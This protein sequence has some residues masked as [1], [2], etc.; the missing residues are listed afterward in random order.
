M[1]VQGYELHAD[2]PG[3]R[4][5]DIT[6]D[7]DSGTR[8]LNLPG[9]RKLERKE[10]RKD[11]ERG[12]RYHFA[13][14]SNGKFRRSIRLPENTDMDNANADYNNGVLHLTFPKEVAGPRKIAINF[15]EEE[16]A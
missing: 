8:S 14:R 5:E 7:I 11:E 15:G 1:A 16:G 3:F 10:E 4:K 13:E 9:E 2:L 6:L 12:T